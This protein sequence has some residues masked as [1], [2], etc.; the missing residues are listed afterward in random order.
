MLLFGN[1]SP[2]VIFSII[3]VLFFG[4]GLH[5]YA[6]AWMA[7]WWGDPTPRQLGRLTPNPLVHIN[8]Q[9]WIMIFLIGFGILGSVPVNPRRM[10]D[11]RWGQFWTSLAGPV[12]NLIQA[13]LFGVLFRLY[14]ATGGDVIFIAQ[15]LYIGVWFNI[16]LFILNL[17]PLGPLDGYRI[18]Y[19]LLPGSWLSSEQV[20]AFIRQNFAPLSR[21]LMYPARVWEQWYQPTFYVL[22]G[23]ILLSFMAGS[24]GLPQLNLLGH[25]IGGPMTG[26]IRLI[27][28]L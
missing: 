26:L 3:V 7:D 25:L 13:V 24:I 11:P 8:W 17:L 27:T 10:R 15:F 28:G 21:F 12:A 2:E 4:M 9:G 6:H 18:L 22:M 1:F 20:P 5:E 23:L 14:D 19:A 16:L